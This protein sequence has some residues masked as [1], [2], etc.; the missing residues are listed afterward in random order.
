GHYRQPLFRLPVGPKDL[1]SVIRCRKKYDAS[2]AA[3]A[4]IITD[5][6]SD[7]STGCCMGHALTT[8]D[9][10]GLPHRCRVPAQ[11]ALTAFQFAMAGLQPGM[12]K[13]GTMALETKAKGNR[14]MNPKDAPDS[15]LLEF[16]PTHA[17][18]HV[19]E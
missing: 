7:A 2:G 13:V 15:G 4:R 19:S 6:I 11:T 3:M 1:Y 16:R 9:G 8:D 10:F 17:A 5:Q 14:T 12:C 18:I